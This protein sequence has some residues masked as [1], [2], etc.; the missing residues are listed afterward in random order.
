MLY[1]FYLV[2][3][4]VVLYIFRHFNHYI[5]TEFDNE[6]ERSSGTTG[7]GVRQKDLQRRAKEQTKKNVIGKKRRAMRAGSGGH[8]GRVE[9][10]LGLN[11][12]VGGG[13]LKLCRDIGLRCTT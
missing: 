13:R 5:F 12:Q 2:A 7:T 8:N 11:L 9:K 6:E 1:T 4:V 3:V 10:Q